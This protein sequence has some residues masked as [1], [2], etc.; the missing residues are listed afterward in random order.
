MKKRT[1]IQ[2]SA[3]HYT[4]WLPLNPIT[5]I[6]CCDCGLVHVWQFKL[7]DVSKKT[8]HL[9]ARCRRHKART[10]K[11]RRGRRPHAGTS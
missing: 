6:E 5:T 4:K 9:Y 7:K 8:S 10:V 3:R 2:K 11:A 1:L